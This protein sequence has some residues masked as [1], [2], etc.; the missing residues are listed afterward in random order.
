MKRVIFILL[1]VCIGIFSMACTDKKTNE[2]DPRESYTIVNEDHA[3]NEF[4][5]ENI[6][7]MC[8]VFLEDYY[9]AAMCGKDLNLENRMTNKEFQQYINLK[10]EY[11]RQISPKDSV[12]IAYGLNSVEWNMEQ[13]Y[14]LL[15]LVTEISGEN[16]SFSEDH[17]FIIRD[18]N[19]KLSIADWYTKG[20]GTPGSLDDAVRGNLKKLYDPKFWEDDESVDQLLRKA[21][22]Y[23][24]LND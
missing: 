24:S 20:L 9:E 2:G 15:D 1:A 8:K 17:Q 7:S 19:G 13:G 23:S 22:R 16:S 6:Y 4:D 3:V 5:F 14:V 11:G 21:E 10:L 18:Q 12:D